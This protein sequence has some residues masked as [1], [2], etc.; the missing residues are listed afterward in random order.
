MIRLLGRLRAVLPA[1]LHRSLVRSYWA[2]F[3]AREEA[4]QRLELGAN[5]AGTLVGSERAVLAEAIAEQYP[6][7][8]LLEV[9]CGYGQLFHVIG[10]QYPN[11]R[12][13]GIDP[14]ASRLD[15]GRTYLEAS[16]LTHVE[17]RQGR[18]EDLSTV[19]DKSFDL[20]VTSAS[21]LYVPPESIEAAVL[22]FRRVARKAIL[23][24]E[25]HVSRADLDRGSKVDAAPGQPA[26]WLRNYRQILERHFPPDRIY[27][28]RVPNPLWTTESWNKHGHLVRVDITGL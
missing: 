28:E 14:D 3:W 12:M 5:A 1:G 27:V 21:L 20:V 15:G 16:G 19:G 7:D 9:G 25:Q 23:L 17:L 8:S 13:L 18:A 11:V 4:R 2:R 24:L 6:F 22:E 10:A 26:Y